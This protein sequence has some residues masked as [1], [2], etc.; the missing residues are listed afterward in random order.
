MEKCDCCSSIHKLHTCTKFKDLSVGD[1]INFVRKAKL[2]FN[3]L[4]SPHLIN[5]CRSRY[6][7][8]VC[9]GKHNTLLHYEKQDESLNT[10]IENKYGEDSAS[11]STQDNSKTLVFQ[12]DTLE[13]PISLWAARSDTHVFLTTAVVLIADHH[14]V[15]RL[16]RA[17]LD[18]GTQVIFITKK[19]AN[20]LKLPREK[21]NLPINGIGAN[22]VNFRCQY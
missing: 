2:C 19:F 17:V 1:L 5:K 22:Q 7:C 20:L 14:S 6:N 13:T 21:N 9:N 12:R 18:S 16:C 11:S 4:Q 3:C 15:Q 10:S 8:F